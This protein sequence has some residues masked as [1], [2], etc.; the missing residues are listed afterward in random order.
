MWS[1]TG[2]T[3]RTTLWN[4]SSAELNA[5]W[6]GK[7]SI[8]CCT[9]VQALLSRR[10]APAGYTGRDAPGADVEIREMRRNYPRTALRDMQR[11]FRFP[12]AT[13]SIS[14]LYRDAWKHAHGIFSLN[15][16]ASRGC[17]FRCNWCAKPI[18]GDS[19]PLA[20]RRRCRG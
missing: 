3:P 17:P 15:L 1:F 10:Q 13:S 7:P 5:F 14:R 19:Y 6:E 9:C 8:R 20:P 4:F 18:F 16:I 12:R 2:R 11:R